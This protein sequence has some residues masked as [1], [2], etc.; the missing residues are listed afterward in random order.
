VR[1]D[2]P[3]DLVNALGH[4]LTKLAPVALYRSAYAK[5]PRKSVQVPEL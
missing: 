3:T 2:D 5:I 1:A 4:S